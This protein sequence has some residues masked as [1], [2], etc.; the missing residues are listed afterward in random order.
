MT[1]F[2]REYAATL[3]KTQEEKRRRQ[4]PEWTTGG[5]CEFVDITGMGLSR[6]PAPL[7][8]VAG[9][10]PTVSSLSRGSGGGPTSIVPESE[11]LAD[12]LVALRAHPRVAWCERTNAGATFRNGRMVTFGF[13]GQSDITG[14]LVTGERLDVE[15]KRQGKQGTEQQLTHLSRVHRAGGVAFVAWSVADVARGLA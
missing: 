12:V 15:C 3:A 5:N 6:I 7:L 9:P 13:P 11:V 8:A 14:Q 10:P 2:S 1:R 4:P